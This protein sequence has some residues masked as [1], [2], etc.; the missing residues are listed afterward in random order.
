MKK[1]GHAGTLDPLASG[2]LVIAVGRESTKR[3][4]Q[5]VKKEKEYIATVKLG[6]TSE[7]DD[8]EGV[9]DDDLIAEN[10][11]GIGRD[12]IEKVLARFIGHIKQVPPVFSAIKVK[13]KTA[14]KLARQGKDPK[15][16]PREV[17]IKEIELLDFQW[18]FIKIRVVTGPGVYIRS[19]ARDIGNELG[20]G[21]YMSDLERTRVGEYTKE[22]SF[23][24][25]EFARE[26]K[27]G[28]NGSN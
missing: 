28:S 20:V 5:V 9:R 17:E 7:T 4:D 14:Y 27:G 13:G 11:K 22:K 19:L 24:I 12:H 16:E 21:A 3:I 15:L 10:L 23:T 26:W 1:V 18:P 2:V 25:E 6:Q 8:A